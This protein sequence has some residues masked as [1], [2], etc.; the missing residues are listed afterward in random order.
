[1][2]KE[3]TYVGC[4]AV[5][6]ENEMIAL[7]KKARGGYKGKLDLPGGGIEYKEM[8]NVTL[9]REIKEE[10]GVNIKSYKLLDVTSNNIKWKMADNLYEDLHHIG[11]LY[12]ASIIDNELKKYPDGH[13][14]N[15]ANWYK[16]TDLKEENLTPFLIFSLKKLGYKL[17]Q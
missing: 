6:I 11:I 3:K 15:G 8:P 14:S 4:Y 2:I 7:I 10:L 1:M 5:V 16:I 12:Q 9:K 17:K 13:D